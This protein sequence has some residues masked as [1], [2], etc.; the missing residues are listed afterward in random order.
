MRK[1]IIAVAGLLILAAIGAATWR[2]L[3]TAPQD[4][5]FAVALKV[6]D[7]SQRAVNGATP[8]Y[9]SVFVSKSRGAQQ[10]R[11]GTAGEPWYAHL[12]IEPLEPQRTPQFRW[13]LLGRPR[14]VYVRHDG[15]ANLTNLAMYEGAEAVFDDVR[16]IYTAEFGLAPEQVVQLPAGRHAYRAVLTSDSWLPWQWRGR[17][18]SAPIWLTV[19]GP[20]VSVTPASEAARLAESA[21]FY[22]RAGR[23]E[24]ARRAAQS[25]VQASP[26]DSGYHMLLGDALNGLRRD[27]DALKEYRDALLL[28]A[29]EKHHGHRDAPEY[30]FMRIEEVQARMRP[31]QP[32]TK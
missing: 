8:L 22:S 17:V 13:S 15:R 10:A 6:G 18:A 11:I 30:L 23:F 32:A 31:A 3:L 25:L 14:S 19:E 16:R 29:A 28:L 7:S 26:T 21:G 5:P 2:W 9:F 1:F 4:P 27:N 20:V 24:D 12:A